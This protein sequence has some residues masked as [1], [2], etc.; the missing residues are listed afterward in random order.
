[1]ETTTGASGSVTRVTRYWSN[2]TY[3][4]KGREHLSS[5]TLETTA[6]LTSL[7]MFGTEGPVVWCGC[8]QQNAWVVADAQKG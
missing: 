3:C 4:P 8:G 7:E 6:I 1:M 5:A 2:G